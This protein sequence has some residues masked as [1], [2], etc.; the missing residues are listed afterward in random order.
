[1]CV[2]FWNKKTQKSSTRISDRQAACNCYTVLFSSVSASLR[3]NISLC[4]QILCCTGRLE[5]G[6]CAICTLIDA[7]HRFLNAYNTEHTQAKIIGVSVVLQV[8][9]TASSSSWYLFVHML[10]IIIETCHSP[11]HV[12]EYIIYIRFLRRFIFFFSPNSQK[13]CLS[14]FIYL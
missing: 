11:P 7:S 4:I 10:L 5:N 8:Q 6:A 9:S 3:M 2:C 13:I 1:M 14:L 12:F